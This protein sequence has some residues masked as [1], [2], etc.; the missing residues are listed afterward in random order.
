M[1]DAKLNLRSWSLNSVKLTIIANK[2]NTAER[3]MTV[4]MLGLQ[5]NPTSDK[6]HLS[7]KSS[8]LANE[9]LMTE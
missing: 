1:G 6:L 4:N 9:H 7:E 3:A 5:W 8:I 2:E